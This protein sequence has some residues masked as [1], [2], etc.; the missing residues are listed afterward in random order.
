MLWYILN[1]AWFSIKMC[2][3]VMY[4]CF[5]FLYIVSVLCPYSL[6]FLDKINWYMNITHIHLWQW[7]P[8]VNDFI[9]L[10]DDSLWEILNWAWYSI[11]M[12][13]YKPWKSSLVWPH[14]N[15]RNITATHILLNRLG[16]GCR[17]CM[18]TLCQSKAIWKAAGV[19]WIHKWKIVWK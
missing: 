1:L 11:K 2:S 8:H 16:R 18:W 13:Y 17:C 4:L 6:L 19:K 15:R 7:I 14:Q 5:S 12:K 10:H 3:I 9:A